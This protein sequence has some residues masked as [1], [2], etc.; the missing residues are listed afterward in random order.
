M[1]PTT[2]LPWRTRLLA[3]DT[4]RAFWAMVPGFLAHLLVM[5]LGHTTKERDVSLTASV[6]MYATFLAA[7]PVLTLVGFAGLSGEPLRVALDTSRRRALTHKGA[8]WARMLLTGQRR[9]RPTAVGGDGASWSVML[10]VLA[11]V[12]ALTMSFFPQLRGRHGLLASTVVLIVA[13]WFGCVVSYGLHYARVDQRFGGLLFPEEVEREVLGADPEPRSFGDYLYT[14]LAVQTT[15][16]PSDVLLS[17]ARMRRIV[18]GQMIVGFA[19]STLVLATVVS[20]VAA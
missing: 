7:Y 1:A 10:G 17:T 20:M 14:A 5:L 12:A 19:F 8:S 9:L 2:E 3:H 15:F 16:S 6:A 13:A 4:H 11:A 18:S